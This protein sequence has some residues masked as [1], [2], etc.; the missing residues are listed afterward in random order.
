MQLQFVT[1]DFADQVVA[2]IMQALDYSIP[3]PTVYAI[4]YKPPMGGP[5]S[6]DGDTN[7][8]MYQL[9]WTNGCDMNA[10]ILSNIYDMSPGIWFYWRF[11]PIY[12]AGG[13]KVED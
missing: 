13:P 10:G 11:M 12:S 7:K 4:E 5:N 9:K 2:K 3:F 8:K 6:P 1:K